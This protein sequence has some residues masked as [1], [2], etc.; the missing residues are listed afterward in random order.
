MRATLLEE[1]FG[2]TVPTPQPTVTLLT[3]SSKRVVRMRRPGCPPRSPPRKR[4]GL[5][6]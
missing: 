3:V 1:G 5:T 4:A 6:G 2:G